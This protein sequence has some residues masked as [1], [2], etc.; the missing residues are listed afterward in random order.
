MARLKKYKD[1]M[2]N[3]TFVPIGGSEKKETLS[4][5]VSIVGGGINVL[6]ITAATEMKQESESKYRKIFEDLD[7]MVC[8]LHCDNAGIDEYENISLLEDC[9]LVFM[10]GGDQSKISQCLLG[11]LFLS[12]LVERTKKGLVVCGTSAGAAVMSQHMI[13]GGRTSPVIGTGLSFLPE[14]IVD[15]HFGERNRLS[16][17]RTAVQANSESVLIGLGLSED[18]GAIVRGRR[19][20]IIGTGKACL[21]TETGEKY[22]SPGESML[23]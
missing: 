20:E 11:T 22:L 12:R 21:V 19:I 8:F 6:V 3:T 2:S 1:F 23:F 7:C 4:K 14:V 13:A 17:L 10:T 18:C 9:D 15:S 16:R 5:V